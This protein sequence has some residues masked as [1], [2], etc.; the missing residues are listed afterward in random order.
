MSKMGFGGI[1][2]W[3]C[4]A[5]GAFYRAVG[6]SALLQNGFA[7]AQNHFGLPQCRPG[8]TKIVRRYRRENLRCPRVILRCAC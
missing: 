3:F 6:F 1:A 4:G 7:A 8:G 2:E 5:A